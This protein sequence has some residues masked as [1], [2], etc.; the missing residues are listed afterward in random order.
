LDLSK[1]TIVNVDFNRADL[2]AADFRKVTVPFATCYDACLTGANFDNGMLNAIVR[3]IRQL[4]RGPAG[5]L[6][7]RFVHR[8]EFAQHGQQTRAP[9]AVV[10]RARTRR[11]ADCRLDLLDAA[12]LV[13][14]LGELDR[15]E[16]QE[17][18]PP[19]VLAALSMGE[20]LS[21]GLRKA[22]AQQCP[23]HVAAQR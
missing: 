13:A 5:Q 14:Q 9:A 10:G 20:D 17:V 19:K 1:S 22:T 6:G 7:A 16:L 12:L 8:V 23:H 2:Y 3:W 21:L 11:V 18:D 15:E 4:D